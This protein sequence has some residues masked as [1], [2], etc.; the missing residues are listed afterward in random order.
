MRK[1]G[2]SGR[3]SKTRAK[4][5]I[6]MTISVAE[7]ANVFLASN[8]RA[9]SNGRSREDK[10]SSGKIVRT[11]CRDSSKK[12]FLCDRGGQGEELLCLWRIWAH[13][14]PL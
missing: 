7:E 10:C 5:N 11:G 3:S 2:T 8:N 14:P 6:A 13:G 1:E 12:R 4:T 9:C